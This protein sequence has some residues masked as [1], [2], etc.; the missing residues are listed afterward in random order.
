MYQSGRCLFFTHF[1]LQV[2]A[3][4]KLSG[5]QQELM[6]NCECLDNAKILQNGPAP[7]REIVWLCKDT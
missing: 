4:Q 1:E 6:D 5:R 2:S 3:L 7:R